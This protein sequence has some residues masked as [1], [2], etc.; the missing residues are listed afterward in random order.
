MRKRTKAIFLTVASFALSCA[1]ISGYDPL[2]DS[3]ASALQQKVETF[4]TDLEQTTGTPEGEY[5]RHAGFYDEVRTDISVL[6]NVASAHKGN[7]ITLQSLDSIEDNLARLEK[8]HA[9]GISAKEISIVRTLFA[10]QFRM[11]VQFENAKKR[12]ES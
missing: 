3:G 9:E 6:R 10:S 12:K 2:I 1:F 7:D 4:L 5:Q 11:L 8:M